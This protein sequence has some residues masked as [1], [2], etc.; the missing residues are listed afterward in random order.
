MV[1]RSY[2]LCPGE[3]KEIS[4]TRRPYK[5]SC[6]DI[7]SSYAFTSWALWTP[8]GPRTNGFLKCLE[9]VVIEAIALVQMV[10]GVS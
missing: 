9:K 2:S 5:E 7:L 3:V 8:N 1:E 10:G 6:F 4:T